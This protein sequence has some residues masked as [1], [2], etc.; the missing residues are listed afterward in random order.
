MQ[1]QSHQPTRERKRQTMNRSWSLT[2]AIIVALAALCTQGFAQSLI[3][4][5]V[6]GTITDPSAAVIPNVAVTLKSLDTG[7]IQNTTSN[8]AGAYRFSL[9][10]PGHY[11]VSAAQ[12][13]FQKAERQVTVEVGQI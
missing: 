5:D 12:S 1:L 8:Q 6:A 13:G 2:L 7:A 11:L 10:K 4:G 3:S 9:L